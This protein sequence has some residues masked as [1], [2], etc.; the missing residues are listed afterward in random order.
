[1]PKVGVV[2]LNWNGKE[3]TLECLESLGKQSRGFTTIVVDNGSTDGL[4]DVLKKSRPD[5]HLIEN[6]WNT[7]FA[8]A[9]NQGI[10]LA[11]DLGCEYV[12]L[13]N[14]DTVVGEDFI[15]RMV[16]AA[17]RNPQAAL[18]VPKVLNYKTLR[19]E[20]A[21]GYLRLMQ[22]KAIQRGFNEVDKGQY[23]KMVEVDF[24]PGCAVLMPISLAKGFG[25]FDS[26]FFA[27]WEDMDLSYRVLKQGKKIIYTPN[28]KV[29]HKVSAS[30]GGYKS[31]L[32][33][34]LG[35][36]N[37]IM[38]MRKQGSW[39]QRLLF[40]L[41]FAGYVPAF[42]SYSFIVGQK[43]QAFAFIRA[44]GSMFAKRFVLSGFR[45]PDVPWKI[46]VNARYAQRQKTGIEYFISNQLESLSR[47]DE[48]NRY[49]LFCLSHASLPGLTVGKNFSFISSGF[50]TEYRL[51]R[52]F[53]EQ[54]LLGVL[55]WW[56]GVDLYHGTSFVLPWVKP[57][58]FVVT[59]YDLSHYKFP[60]WYT[61]ANRLYLNLL[62]RGSVNHADVVL[63]ISNSTKQDLINLFNIEE[64]KIHVAYPGVDE[65]F[66][67]RATP[68]K[69]TTL[70]KRYALPDK[71]FLFV[72]TIS[73]R[74]NVGRVIRAIEQIKDRGVVV[75]LVLVGRKGWMYEQVFRL[76]KERKLDTMV[77]VLDYVP[78]EDIPVLYQMA[79]ALVFPSLYEGFGMPVLEAMASRCPV[80]TSTTSSLPEAAGDAALLVDP[81]SVEEIAKACERLMKDEELREQMKIKGVIH[82]RNFTW[83]RTA[84]ETLRA[85]ELALRVLDGSTK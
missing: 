51:L 11:K 35:T 43:K 59:V 60:G 16:D 3:H 67:V 79:E 68:D 9:N 55:L 31:P 80:I 21:G 1:M 2:I 20:S 54:V 32:S 8:Y 85:Y 4:L 41:Y 14:N 76:I 74:K 25:V 6:K 77:S 22:G 19:I 69:L 75:P 39:Y 64:K 29:W 48:K 27:Y 84:K 70:R 46:G 83:E 73:P 63:T 44:V 49:S 42:V 62:L 5:I 33:V 24:A 12:I 15:E 57:C 50:Q 58:P 7:G 40:Y 13:L 47:L 71:F 26:A 23:D 56:R 38:F 72:S 78:D 28:A 34:Y 66:F 30:T 37:R 65:R 61:L 53:W 18:V 52:I 82:A 36:R 10:S 81:E 45:A 17:K